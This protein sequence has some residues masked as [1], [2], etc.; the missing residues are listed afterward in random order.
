VALVLG[1][2]IGVAVKF[3]GVES[4]PRLTA[5]E[6][7]LPGVNCGACGS[8]GCA[9]FARAL[10]AGTA[11]PRLCPSS[12]EA[13]LEQIAGIL[14]LSL[15]ERVNR[16]AVVRCGGGSDQ[17]S[18][19]RYNGVVD[20]RSANPVAGGGKGCAQGCLGYGT[21]ARACPFKAIEMTSTGLAVV[22]ADLCVGCGKCVPACPRNLILLVPRPSEVHVFCSSKAKGADKAKVCRV[23]CIGC[24]KC[25]KA[26]GEGRMEM[27]GFLARV[28]YQNPPGPEVADVCPTHCLQRRYPVGV[29]DSAGL[30]IKG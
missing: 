27:D 12:S 17:A 7:L 11:S 18:G 8:A 2:V 9:D 25:V 3:F 24:R 19:T 13:N 30:A 26:A 22:H 1:I 29:A 5:V 10:V 23:S 6:G 21:C 15:G 4:D 14:G 20:C 16:V 28:N